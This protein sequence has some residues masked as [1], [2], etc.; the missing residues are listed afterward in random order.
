MGPCT[1]SDENRGLPRTDE[2]IEFIKEKCAALIPYKLHQ[3]EYGA[4]S[5]FQ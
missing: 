5:Q 2:G 4:T 1:W 3:V